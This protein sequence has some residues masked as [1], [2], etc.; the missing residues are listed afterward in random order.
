MSHLHPKYTACEPKQ[1]ASVDVMDTLALALAVVDTA[2][3][4]HTR[5]ALAVVPE[6]LEP[7]LQLAAAVL[8]SL[9]MKNEEVS[10]VIDDFRRTHMSELS[11]LTKLS[12][13]SLGYGFDTDH[14]DD[15]LEGGADTVTLDFSAGD[16]IDAMDGVILAQ[17][18]SNSTGELKGSAA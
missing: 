3:G 13:G 8:G 16:E 1:H 18:S 15:G 7:S 2:C 9:K 5:Q 11:F 17:P 12:G 10:E 4:S 6:I 14:G